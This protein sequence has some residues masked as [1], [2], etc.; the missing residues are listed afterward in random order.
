MSTLQ[1]DSRAVET[2]VLWSDESLLLFSLSNPMDLSGFGSLPGE[3]YTCLTA[4]CQV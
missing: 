3:Q 1:L 4:L 2:C